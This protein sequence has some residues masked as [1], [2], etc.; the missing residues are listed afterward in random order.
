MKGETNPPSTADHV[1]QAAG[2][3]GGMFAGAAIGTTAG[4]LGTLLGGIAGAI[5]GW[6]TGRA[7]AEA[8]EDI[9]EADEA[10]YREHF[11]QSNAAAAYFAGA[12]RAYYLGDFAAANPDYAT[13]ED[14]E[15]ELGR[16]WNET[17]LSLGEW[18]EVRRYALVGFERRRELR[19]AKRPPTITPG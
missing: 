11:A 19:R 3:L 17:A 8:A 1:G 5:G 18:Q 16:G 7:I 13:F 6:W 10:Y 14:A 12:R 15:R 4:P 9:T 2:G